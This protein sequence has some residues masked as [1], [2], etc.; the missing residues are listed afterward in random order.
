MSD[1]IGEIRDAMMEKDEKLIQDIINANK[2]RKEKY[3]IVVYFKPL[4]AQLDGKPTLRK[5][6]KPYG[7]KPRSMVG[8][9]IAEVDNEAGTITWE[10]NMPDIPLDHGGILKIGGKES[11]EPIIETQ[12]IAG[13]Y[14]HK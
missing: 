7:Q 14:L 11:T 13:A 12:S 4:K 6:I 3:W 2:N 1:E 8:M 9:N 5:H 10:I